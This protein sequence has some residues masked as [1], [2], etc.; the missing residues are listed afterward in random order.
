[1]AYLTKYIMY[2]KNTLGKDGVVAFMKNNYSGEYTEIIGTAEPVVDGF[3]GKDD[4]VET[5]IKV[6]SWTI[7]IFDIS[8]A[9]YDEFF[10]SDSRMFKI[11]ITEDGGYVAA[12]WLDV[13]NYTRPLFNYREDIQITVNDGLA[14]LKNEAWRDINGDDFTGYVTLKDAICACLYRTNLGLPLYESCD[15]YEAGMDETDADSPFTQAKFQA[16]LFKKTD[17]TFESCYDVLEQLLKRFQCEVYQHLGNWHITRINNRIDSFIRRLFNYNAGNYTYASN[18]SWDP[19]VEIEGTTRWFWD[20]PMITPRPAWKKF[21]LKQDYG[22]DANL[23]RVRI[24]DLKEFALDWAFLPSED[25]LTKFAAF[26]GLQY[27]AYNNGILKINRRNTLFES[28]Y[29]QALVYIEDYSGQRFKLNLSFEGN[30]FVAIRAMYIS[31]TK[32][33]FLDSFGVWFENDSS[34]YIYRSHPGVNPFNPIYINDLPGDGIFI[35]RIYPPYSLAYEGYPSIT[36]QYANG[37]LSIN[38]EDIKL[39][40]ES[41]VGFDDSITETTAINENNFYVP[42]PLELDIGDIPD[43]PNAHLIYK[44]GLY[45]DD[46]I[47]HT[48]SWHLKDNPTVEK[49]LNGLLSDEISCNHIY[50]SFIISGTMHGDIEVGNTIIVDGIV[51]I[52]TRASHNRYEND[53]DIDMIQ[54]G[55]TEE[56]QAF[57]KLKSGGYIRLKDGG[58]IKIGT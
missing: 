27:T 45:L 42:D 44:G 3:K 54:I 52:I 47:N 20:T 14:G 2:Y 9:T 26:K 46:G 38:P 16:D 55:I 40:L 53:I 22:Y 19:V 33:Y 18:A 17:G 10:T 15:I 57:L 32:Q 41:L 34:K 11:L 8:V 7:T 31:G 29:L 51:F 21:I 58:K 1:M 43:I 13:D 12:G 39:E 49:T 4:E 23:L 6:K 30:L 37:I 24:G 36:S 56:K 25:K 35:L 48:S 28:Q 5:P 50:S